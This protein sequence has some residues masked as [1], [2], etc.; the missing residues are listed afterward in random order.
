MTSERAREL[1]AAMAGGVVVRYLGGA[2]ADFL[3]GPGWVISAALAWMGTMAIGQVATSYFEGGK[4]LSAPELRR[5][6][7][8]V[9]QKELR[10]TSFVWPAKL[11]C[12]ALRALPTLWV[13]RRLDFPGR[14]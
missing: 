8:Q 7:D 6:Y 9:R 4:Q 10:A 13:G 1:L 5:L 11:T 14:Q 2:L 3:P 12:R